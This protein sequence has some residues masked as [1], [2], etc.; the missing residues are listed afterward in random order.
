MNNHSINHSKIENKTDIR[1]AINKYSRYWYIFPIT[2]LVSITAGFFYLTIATKTY[3]VRSSLLLRSSEQG[4]S[5]PDKQGFSDNEIFQV[6]QKVDNKT[7]E[8]KSIT[9]VDRAVRELNLQTSFF[10]DGFLKNQEIY[11]ARAPIKILA[12]RIDIK[13]ISDDVIIT[14]NNDNQTFILKD[15]I[16]TATYRFGQFIRRSYAD[17]IVY[18][19]SAAS[20]KVNQPI[21][22]EF[23]TSLAVANQFLP[24]LSVTPTNENADVITITFET[25]VPQKGKD[26]LNK[27]IELS[28][29]EEVEDKNKIAFH[30]IKFIDKR[31]DSLTEQLSGVE[32]NVEQLKQQNNLTD[33]NSNAEQYVR[34]SGEYGQELATAET[35]LSV[36]RY[37]ESY[38]R[39][40]GDQQEMVPSSLGI[41]D[42][43]L[44]NLI[45]NFN[46]L[47]L[48]KQ[49]LLRTVQNDNPLVINVSEQ[50]S[51]LQ[52]SIIENINN[53][54]RGLSITRN[55]LR[56]STSQFENKIK[57]VPSV[58]RRML[59]IKRDQTLKENLYLYLLQ[60][61]EESALSLAATVS[62]SRVIEK[63]NV[64]PNP[65]SPQKNF[66]YLLALIVGFGIPIAGI[67]TKDA[68]NNKIQDINE[69]KTLSSVTVL[70]ELNRNE[71]KEKIVVRSDS[72]TTISE[73]FRLIRTNLQYYY[74]DS[75]N[76]VILVT[77]TMSGEG[78]TFF[79]ANL[80]ATLAL[81]NKKVVVLEFDLRNPQ[82]LKSI[83][84]TQD[85][86]GITEY[87]SD[88]DISF[89][90]L[91]KSS[92]TT[93]I[94]D[95]IGAGVIPSNPADLF[96]SPKVGDLID[97]LRSTYDHIIIDSS[98]IGQVADAFS[99][100]PFVDSSVFM[101]RYNYTLK[102]QINTL[103]DVSSKLKNTMVVLNDA[104]KDNFNGY[105]YSYGYISNKKVPKLLG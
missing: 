84:V 6:S 18:N 95:I 77:S 64:K 47:Q 32:R 91:I 12:K 49:R 98:P 50:L 4:S 20:G 1:E 29:K 46:T 96:Y 104:N 38:F 44:A 55:N 72:T 42:A 73:L 26:F 66:V 74:K 40:K 75:T 37:I 30:T 27:L 54:K 92:Y 36:L 48:E 28:G 21:K 61:R 99:L 68:V 71:S 63:V 19:N 23:K 97:G 100:V 85:K 14:I 79:S 39:G 41:Q 11:G 13:G 88:N 89:G 67:Y 17:F 101:V 82:L 3:E 105:G 80:A 9:L 31:L 51:S 24:K 22:V 53:I 65:I 43:T 2:L 58:E 83:G 60:K 15:N 102:S 94:F 103:N 52:G 59:Q 86:K 5:K 81:A 69:F 56:S 93:P 78:K 87:L 45:A 70:G 35:Q 10:I 62:N 57:S 25:A 76:K 90:D 33:V 16:S 34:Q 7:Q 8:L